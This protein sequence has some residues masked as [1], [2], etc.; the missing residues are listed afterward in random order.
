MADI[1]HW[2]SDFHPT[3]KNHKVETL[4]SVSERSIIE[5]FEFISF[6]FLQLGFL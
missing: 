5:Q 2:T 4:H 1:D 3:N 6:L